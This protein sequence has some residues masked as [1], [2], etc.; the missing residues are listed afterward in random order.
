VRAFNA[1]NE[2]VYESGAYD[3]AT[4]VLGHDADLRL[5]EAELGIS[6][7]LAA[8]LGLAAGPSF[9]FVLND[10][11]YK[12][13]RIPPRGFTNAGF[14]LVQA[15][16]VDPDWPGPEPR[17]ADGQHWDGANYILP[18]ASD[19]LEVTLY[20]QTTSKEYV[21]FLRDEN[22][23]NQAGNTMHS[24]W[25]G[26]G[27]A[28]PVAMATEI[29]DVGSTAVAGAGTP[30]LVFGL[31]RP[32]P[33]PFRGAGTIAYRLAVRGEVELA[34]YDVHGRRVRTLLDGETAPSGL[35]R[36]PWDGRDESGHP[37]ASGLYFV[38]LESGGGSAVERLVLVK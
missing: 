18:V 2:L 6:P 25:T 36:V 21:E 22:T 17:Y 5:Y 7:G 3:A 32:S 31:E 23:T 1:A 9:H 24:A 28:A 20:Y 34:V 15:T 10:S 33:H 27:R 12:D 11:I 38:R 8:A 4:G 30:P 14:A 16:P 26:N 29:M 19:R 13:N 37:A 35:H